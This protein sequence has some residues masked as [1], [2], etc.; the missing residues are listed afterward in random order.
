[1]RL[2]IG[3]L[4]AGIFMNGFGPT[5]VAMGRTPVL[6]TAMVLK[7]VGIRQE[8]AKIVSLVEGD[9]VFRYEVNLLHDNRLVLDLLDVDSE[10]VESVIPVAHPLL[11]RIRIGR[12]NDP[13]MTRLVYDLRDAV[14]YSVVPIGRRLVVTLHESAPIP[15]EA[16]VESSVPLSETIFSDGEQSL[17]VVMQGGIAD[18]ETKGFFKDT[19]ANVET[20][21]VADE[22]SLKPA[23]P[24]YVGRKIS[25]DFQSANL[26]SVLRMIAEVS[27]RNMV[28]GEA[29]NG[30]VAIRLLNV[31]WDQG[32]DVIM[33]MHS[34]GKVE[35]GKV[36]FI[37]TLGNITQQQEDALREQEVALRVKETELSAQELVT[38]LIPVNYGDIGEIASIVTD[39]LSMR[40]D[41][42][43]DTRTKTLIVRDVKEKI[44]VLRELV[45]KMDTRT[46]QVLIEARIVQANRNFAQS[47]GIQ[48][49]VRQAAANPT[50]PFTFQGVQSG[51]GVG[52]PVED[53]LVNFPATVAGAPT[54]G[55]TYGKLLGDLFTLDMRL[56]AGETLALVNVVSSPKVVTLDNKKAVIQQGTKVPFETTSLQGTQTT[57]VDAALVL[58]VEPHVILHDG[59]ISLK[60][61]A[62]KNSVGGLTFEAGPIIDTKEAQTEVLVN[63]GET[64]VIGGILEDVKT[65]QT[66]GIPYLSK[67]PGLGWL[68]KNKTTTVIKTEL[69]IFLTPSV[70]K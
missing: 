61:V 70:L 15:Q 39:Q 58:D 57:F 21:S 14:Q 34:L 31:P 38:E 63:D 43:Q 40:G 49:G 9:G 10:I 29:V 1:M 24:Q 46:P 52:Q 8:P 2:I 62:T 54:A 50:N 67:I 11:H 4:A 51:S 18:G 65:E 55:F 68:F 17:S 5:D 69:L 25:L 12:H 22:L 59:T 36:I 7:S 26:R 41:L 44:H 42:K 3:V 66:A 53:F 20:M 64:I 13:K 48:W 60:I 16:I 56:S 47:L 6:K 35:W 23:L 19:E 37:D 33:R 32:L 45:R 28:I 27:E 30:K